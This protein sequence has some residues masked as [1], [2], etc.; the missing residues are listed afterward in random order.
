MD[1]FV[2]V[3]RLQNLKMQRNTKDGVFLMLMQGMPSRLV[4]C[5]ESL[6]KGEMIRFETE[7]RRVFWNTAKRV[8]LSVHFHACL[9]LFLLHPPSFA[10]SPLALA[11]TVSTVPSA[12]HQP[13]T[14][15]VKRFLDFGAARD[16]AEP[17]PSYAHWQA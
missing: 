15:V 4:S 8:L 16:L 6:G 1:P 3:A 17:L 7:L 12:S 14:P 10:F 9:F 11:N 13:Q 5:C 2:V